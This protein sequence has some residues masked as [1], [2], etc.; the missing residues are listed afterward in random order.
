MYGGQFY[1]KNTMEQSFSH[2]ILN[3]NE[4]RPIAFDCLRQI[5]LNNYSFNDFDFIYLYFVN[6]HNIWLHI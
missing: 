3:K 5:N 1:Q 2:N 4:S 6:S